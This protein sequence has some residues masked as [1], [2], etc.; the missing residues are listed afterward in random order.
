MKLTRQIFAAICLALAVACAWLAP[1]D[2]PATAKVDAGL[3]RAL[4]SFATARALHGVL[5]VVQGTQFSA[6]PLGVGVS[7]TPGQLLAPVNDL[8]K[9]FSDFMLAASVAFGIMKMSIAIGA[10]WPVSAALTV[11]AMGWGWLYLRRQRSPGWLSKIFVVLLMVRFA[12]PLAVLGT[13]VLWQKFLAADYA[14]TQMAVDGAAGQAVRLNPPAAV[15]GSFLERAR[16][17]VANTTDV[18]AR[19]EDIKQ[20]AERV[21]EHIVKLMVIF[22]LQTLIIPLLLVWLLYAVLKGVVGSLAYRRPQPL[23]AAA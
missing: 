19:F 3:K 2:L 14:S 9:N 22:L 11:T 20:T 23:R 7:L 8:V 5:S 1:I 13:D 15:N 16:E 18:K 6:Q 17:W 21:T 12:I 4:I 10:Y